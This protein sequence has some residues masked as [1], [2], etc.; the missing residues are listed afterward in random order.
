MKWFYSSYE[1]QPVPTGSWEVSPGQ[2]TVKCL[3]KDE[4]EVSLRGRGERSRQKE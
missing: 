1:G 2:V 3:L 4:E